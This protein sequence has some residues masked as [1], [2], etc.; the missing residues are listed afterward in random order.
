MLSFCLLLGKGGGDG[1]KWESGLGSE[2]RAVGMGYEGF[3][4]LKEILQACTLQIMPAKTPRGNCGLN[5]QVLYQY[6]CYR[7]TPDLHPDKVNLC[8]ADKDILL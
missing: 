8:H 6:T 2:D 3:K 4:T 7:F 5:N 1:R